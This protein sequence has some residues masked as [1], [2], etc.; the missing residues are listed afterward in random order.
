MVVEVRRRPAVG[1]NLTLELKLKL[2]LK[3]KSST[4]FHD[5]H[6][7]LR[8]I[9]SWKEGDLFNLLY[10]LIVNYMYFVNNVWIYW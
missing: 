3:L 7:L 8:K 9:L 5:Q 1:N 6:C 2:K 4:Y 10:F